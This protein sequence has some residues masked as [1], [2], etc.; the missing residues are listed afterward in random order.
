MTCWS[1]LKENTSEIKTNLSKTILFIANL[2]HNNWR[3][4]NQLDATYYFIVLLT[5]STCFGHYY[6]HHQ[7]LATMMLITI[8]VV[9]FLVCCMLEVR[10]SYAGVV[11][12]LQSKAPGHLSSLHAPNPQHTAYQERYDQCGS[13]HHSF[14]LLMMGRIMSETCSALKKC[15]KITSGI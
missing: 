4:R 8:L 12:G 5:G 14:E 1:H 3:T 6:A 9:S 10:C 2:L 7:E 13:Q 11:S 15:N